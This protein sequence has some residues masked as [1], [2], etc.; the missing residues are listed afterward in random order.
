MGRFPHQS[1]VLDLKHNEGEIYIAASGFGTTDR[2]YPGVT[3]NGEEIDDG[4]NHGFQQFKAEME[5][6]FGGKTASAKLNTRIA[7]EL[8]RIARELVSSDGE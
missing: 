6:Y 7:G 5:N 4:S 3:F 8:V 1:L 2:G